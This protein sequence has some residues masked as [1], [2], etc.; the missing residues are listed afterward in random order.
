MKGS[1]ETIS[2]SG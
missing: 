2:I 1:W